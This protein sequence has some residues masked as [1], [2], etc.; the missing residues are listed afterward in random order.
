M[1][2]IVQY[3]NTELAS[4]FQK[5]KKKKKEKVTS[6]AFSHHPKQNQVV[7]VPTYGEKTIPLCQPAC[8]PS[9]RHRVQ[10]MVMGQ[11]REQ[12]KKIRLRVHLHT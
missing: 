2:I 4:Q 11:G 3:I 7:R 1:A 12:I 9:D 6:G 5:L 8:M 10:V